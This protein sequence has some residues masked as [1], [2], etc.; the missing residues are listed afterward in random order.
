MGSS[1]WHLF[2]AVVGAILIL[3]G[4]AAIGGWFS[5]WRVPRLVGIGD[6]AFGVMLLLYGLLSQYLWAVLISFAAFV[7]GATCT[8]TWLVRRGH[9]AASR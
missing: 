5:R 9:Q 4:A 8:V 2:E 3:L 7:V 6:T 1:V